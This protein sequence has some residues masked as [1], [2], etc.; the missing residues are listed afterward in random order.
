[1]LNARKKG[2]IH[3]TLYG[4][5]CDCIRRKT[6]YKN[7]MKILSSLWAYENKIKMLVVR[8]HISSAHFATITKAFDA[9]ITTIKAIAMLFLLW[10]FC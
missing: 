2:E 4:R 5:N 1:M 6:S 10:C 8:K 3:F 7:I 9:A